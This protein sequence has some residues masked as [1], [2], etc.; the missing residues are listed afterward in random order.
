MD[1]IS[2]N[3]SIFIA[4]SNKIKKKKKIIQKKNIQKKIKIVK[5]K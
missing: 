1:E 4:N 2:S 5:R 3:Y